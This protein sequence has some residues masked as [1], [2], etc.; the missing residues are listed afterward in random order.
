MCVKLPATRNIQLE[1]VFYSWGNAQNLRVP[2]FFLSPS[3]YYSLEIL[4]A[5]YKDC[6]ECLLVC[7]RDGNLNQNGDP[8]VGKLTYFE[9]WKC[10]IS[11]GLPTPTPM[12]GQTIDRCITLG[13]SKFHSQVQRKTLL[14]YTSSNKQVLFQFCPASESL[15]VVVFY[16][17]VR[18]P[19]NSDWK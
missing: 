2:L 3:N 9:N 6:C 18:S 13:I 15:I 10:Q 17:W 4:S 19:F 1:Y 16:L 8:R 14:P 5:G 12:L 7:P 11:L